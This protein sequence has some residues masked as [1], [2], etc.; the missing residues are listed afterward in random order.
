MENKE[1][2]NTRGK[3]LGYWTGLLVGILTG[4][5]VAFVLIRKLFN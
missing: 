2:Y 4:G 5:A 1:P 3:T